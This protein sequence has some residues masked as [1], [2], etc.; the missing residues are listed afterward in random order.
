MTKWLGWGTRAL[1]REGGEKRTRQ[2]QQGAH[3]VI[4][5][6]ISISTEKERPWHTMMEIHGE[7]CNNTEDYYGKK[8]RE[9]K[10][11]TK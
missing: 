4:K 9:A 2:Q 5:A 6:N 3:T 10:G 8:K 7:V 1:S 11:K